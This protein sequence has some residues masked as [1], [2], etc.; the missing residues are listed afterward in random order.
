MTSSHDK[1]AAAAV[2]DIAMQTDGEALTDAIRSGLLAGSGGIVAGALI[3]AIKTKMDADKRKK[4][5]KA[6]VESDAPVVRAD[7]SLRDSAREQQLMEE[8]A[9]VPEEVSKVASAVDDFVAQDPAGHEPGLVTKGLM[10]PGRAGVALLGDVTLEGAN[11]VSPSLAS[12]LSDPTKKPWAA[13]AAIAAAMAAAYGGY[14]GIDWLMDKLEVDD[15]EADYIRKRNLYQSKVSE[16]LR[17]K[18]GNPEKVA[19]I[20]EKAASLNG[21]RFDGLVDEDAGWGGGLAKEAS[22]DDEGSRILGSAAILGMLGLGGMSYVMSK[23]YFDKQSE[24]RRRFKAI[25]REA[26]QRYLNEST[27]VLI[28]ADPDFALG[29]PSESEGVSEKAKRRK[30]EAVRTAIP[31]SEALTAEIP[32]LLEDPQGQLA[33]DAL[34]T[35]AK[36][37]DDTPVLAAKGTV[38]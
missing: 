28:E 32:A 19:S 20:L 21:T 31:E 25:D 27:P 22:G 10:Q 15:E 26:K 9:D 6:V 13:S 24:S 35:E 16:A 37:E 36:L 34:K 14:K 4:L 11:A 17:R 7:S 38:A 29:M 12:Y 33:H 30:A 8:G 18:Y 2:T 3:H 1:T 5:F 23:R